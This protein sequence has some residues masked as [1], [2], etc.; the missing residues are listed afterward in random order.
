MPTASHT[1]ITVVRPALWRETILRYLILVDAY[2][3]SVQRLSHDEIYVTGFIHPRFEYYMTGLN[4]VGKISDRNA[5]SVYDDTR[6]RRDDCSVTEYFDIALIFRYHVLHIQTEINVSD[7]SPSPVFQYL[8]QLRRY[9]D[10][11]NVVPRLFL[12]VCHCLFALC[13]IFFFPGNLT[14]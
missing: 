14:D 3:G 5:A 6:R 10:N 11:N 8:F 13:P 4:I 1:R 12:T 7:T 2:G 9:F